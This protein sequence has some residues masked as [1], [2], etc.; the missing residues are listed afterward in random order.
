VIGAALRGWPAS[1]SMRST[2]TGDLPVDLG[3]DEARELAR[4]ELSKPSYDR[5]TPITTRVIQWIA[6]RIEDL[7]AAASGTFSSGLAIAVIVVIVVA[8]AVLVVL[9][10]GPLARR[11]ARRAAPVLPDQRRT[12]SD[13]RAAADDAAGDGDWNTAVL[14]RFRAVIAGLEERGVLDT[15][16]GRTADEAAVEAGAVLPGVAEILRAGATRFDAVRYGAR[17]AGPADDAALRELDDAVTTA[18]PGRPTEAGAAE[19][20]VPR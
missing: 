20:A 1:V 15:R 11:G 9:R 17:H 13:H 10:T 3:R 5:D 16:A 6:E 7:L 8:L 18:R 2:S 12:A 14:E 19:F 4:Q